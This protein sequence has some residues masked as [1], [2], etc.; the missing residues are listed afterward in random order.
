MFQKKTAPEGREKKTYEKPKMTRRQK[1]TH[2]VLLAAL[3]LIIGATWMTRLPRY[4]ANLFIDNY[5]GSSS[6]LSEMKGLAHTDGDSAL[7]L[8][9]QISFD[10]WKQ[11]TLRDDVTVTAPDGAVLR[12]GLYDAGSDVTVILLHSFDGS[13]AESDYLFAPFYAGKGYNILLP[14]NRA[15]G[16]SGGTCVTYG[17]AEGGDV[18]AWVELLLERYGAEHQVILHG[19]TLGGSAALA[20]AAAVEAD[21]ALAGSVKF[22]VAESPSVNLYDSAVYLLRNQFRMPSPVALLCDHYAK[23]SLGQSMKAIDLAELTRGCDTPLLMLQGTED[24]VVDPA[25]VAAFCEGYSGPSEL[26]TAECAHGMVYAS[27]TADCQSV[28][29]GYIDAYIG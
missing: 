2:V 10:D 17:R 8:P 6:V 4:Y 5:D 29:E 19:D 13:S 16:E 21:P 11:R 27:R 7:L 14:D 20:G 22:V 26:F 15:H 12:G 28:L 3:L 23:K 18:A 1:I 25:A 9:L 24:A